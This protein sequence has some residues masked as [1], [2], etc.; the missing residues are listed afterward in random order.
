M[1]APSQTRSPLMQVYAQHFRFDLVSRLRS[2]ARMLTIV[3]VAVLVAAT[4]ILD[5]APPNTPLLRGLIWAGLAVW[6]VTF[7]L[8]YRVHAH[9]LNSRI[10][11]LRL[12]SART[13]IDQLT[14]LEPHSSSLRVASRGGPMTA[15]ILEEPQAKVFRLEAAL[16][17]SEQKVER[18]LMTSAITALV[19]ALGIILA[20]ALSLYLAQ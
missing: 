15:R 19:N 12:L 20:A 9:R 8:D 5:Q 18:A 13:N 1:R 11:M 3:V 4:T 14:W 6:L 7:A 10:I 17:Q 2:L 16:E